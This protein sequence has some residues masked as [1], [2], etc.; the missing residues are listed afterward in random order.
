MRKTGLEDNTVTIRA[1][2]APRNPAL[3]QHVEQRR[4]SAENRIADAITA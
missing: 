4:S 2:P 3:L 1:L